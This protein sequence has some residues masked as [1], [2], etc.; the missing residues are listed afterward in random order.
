MPRIGGIYEY[1]SLPATP[2]RHSPKRESP[3]TRISQDPFL[4]A[5]RQNPSMA[6]HAEARTR[7]LLDD[8]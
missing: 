5:I 4:Q 6:A 7:E 8:V 3:Y 1:G 2:G